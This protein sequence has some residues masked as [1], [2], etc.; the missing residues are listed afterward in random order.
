MTR[1]YDQMTVIEEMGMA[2]R[3]L[4]PHVVRKRLSTGILAQAPF[5]P[6]DHIKLV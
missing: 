4:R 1:A 5:F 6:K 3:D 2:D